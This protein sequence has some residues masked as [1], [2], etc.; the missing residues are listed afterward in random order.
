MLVFSFNPLFCGSLE[1]PGVPCLCLVYF[2]YSLLLVTLTLHWIA[3]SGDSHTTVV[4]LLTDSVSLQQKMKSGMKNP[5][6]HDC[7]NV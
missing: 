6:R 1:L 4:S 7:V 2:T 5:G 3:S